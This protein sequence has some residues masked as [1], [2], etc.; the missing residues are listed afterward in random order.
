MLH[1]I[2][3]SKA[4]FVIPIEKIQSKL[5]HIK[6]FIF[7]WDGVFND[8]IKNFDSPS[9]Y[10]E[11]DSMGTNLLRFGCWNLTQQMP[12]MA[13]ITGAYNPTAV[14]FAQREHFDAVYMSMKDKKEALFHF[15]HTYH[16]EPFEIAYFF[17]DANDIGV[18]KEVGLR[19]LIRRD[20]TPLFMEFAKN[21]GFCD[22]ISAH[23]GGNYAVR[24]ICE[25][26]L[27]LQNQYQEILT[28]RGVFS[29][30]F[31][32][33]FTLR[34]KIESIFYKKEAEVIQKLS[35]AEILN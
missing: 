30:V 16:I 26:L 23:E 27:A 2:E 3:N 4:E 32:A 34:Q 33:Y 28:H 25:T 20:A 24:E 8:G 31:S 13:I 22:Y 10:A 12:M 18:A 5:A 6:A 11:A 14:Q 17:D 35:F 15:C 1:L 19:F 21:D 7:D 9:A 29:E